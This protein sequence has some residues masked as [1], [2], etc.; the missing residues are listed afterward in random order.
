M[1]VAELFRLS[2]HTSGENVSTTFKKIDTVL[3]GLLERHESQTTDRRS[4]G[5][6]QL[7][8]LTDG[9][10]PGE[11][12]VLASRAD[13][14]RQPVLTRIVDTVAM[15]H[16]L[17]VLIFS[18]DCDIEN[19]GRYRIGMQFGSY[20]RP[21]RF[22]SAAWQN[23]Q[24]RVL[25]A[26]IEKYK[27]APIY[28]ND[29][30][31]LS[32]DDMFENAEALCDQDEKLG[33]IVVTNGDALNLQKFG[34][35]R[36]DQ[37]LGLSEALKKLALKHCCTVL[38]ESEVSRRLEKRK[39]GRMEPR[40]K[41][42]YGRGAL[43]KYADMLLFVHCSGHYHMASKPRRKFI[44]EMNRTGPTGTARIDDDLIFTSFVRKND[45]DN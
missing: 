21:G 24:Q 42:L 20:W 29:S 13:M 45:S 11:L 25:T 28:V 35:S 30:A 32:I 34:I 41:D 40:T 17:A 27:A 44:I 10:A 8:E 37:L 4:S 3:T 5:F 39:R 38:V 7:D 16:R 26:L 22:H 9:F 31:G 36:Y 23:K 2:S 18:A 19:Y 15:Q 6:P 33:L 12:L 1:S 14:A 43:A